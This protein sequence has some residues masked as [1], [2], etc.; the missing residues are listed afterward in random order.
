MK[1]YYLS[2]KKAEQAKYTYSLLGKAFKRQTKAT[3]D[4]RNKQVESIRN[5]GQVRKNN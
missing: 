3:E 5:Q 4:Q 2:I 1:K